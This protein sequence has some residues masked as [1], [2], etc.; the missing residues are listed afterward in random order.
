MEDYV[1]AVLGLCED[2]GDFYRSR[3]RARDQLYPI[4]LNA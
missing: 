2:S 4:A 1:S 3:R